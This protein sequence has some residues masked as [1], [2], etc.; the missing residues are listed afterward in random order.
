ASLALAWTQTHG[1][2]D[3]EAKGQFLLNMHQWAY[4]E[5]QSALGEEGFFGALGALQNAIEDVVS[6]GVD[7]AIQT[8]GSPE[9][10]ARRRGLTLG[11]QL[12]FQLGI[13]P[14]EEAGA[15]GAWNIVSGITDGITELGL[16]P[17]AWAG[18]VG[19]GVKAAKTIPLASKVTKA[20]RLAMAA[21]AMLPKPFTGAA[22]V[23]GG[24]IARVLYSFKAKT[25]DDLIEATA[26]NGVADDI[27][28]TVKEGSFTKFA[29]RYPSLAR[30]PT[31]MFD[32]ISI[33]DNGD[34]VAEVLRMG[35]LND[36]LDLDAATA[37][38]EARRAADSAKAAYASRLADQGVEVG[39]A[40]TIRDMVF[41]NHIVDRDLA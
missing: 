37:L 5:Q 35:A 27:L 38:D 25:F 41:K 32:A 30:M 18:A 7:L 29:Q 22:K 14:P 6:S 31:E 23:H 16:D 4:Q 28:R 20:G 17:F 13:R 15:M 33:A 1:L 3:D 9:E 36:I 26:R 2:E 10:A 21:R 12:A 11:Q 24:R 34:E 8:F 40:D 39:K 19:A